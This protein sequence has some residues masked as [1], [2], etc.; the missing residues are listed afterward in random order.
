MKITRLKTT[1]KMIIAA[2]RLSLGYHAKY[3]IYELLVVY[4]DRGSAWTC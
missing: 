1:A 3:M 4:V 2:Y